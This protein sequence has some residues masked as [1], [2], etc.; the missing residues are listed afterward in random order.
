MMRGLGQEALDGNNPSANAPGGGSGFRG[1]N[2]STYGLTRKKAPK[3]V[4]RLRIQAALEQVGV[5]WRYATKFRYENDPHKIKSAEDRLMWANK[6]L[7][8]PWTLTPYEFRGKR[9]Q[10]AVLPIRGVA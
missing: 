2:E 9:P 8:S 3:I 6:H 1:V 7:A 10:R 5:F 4:L